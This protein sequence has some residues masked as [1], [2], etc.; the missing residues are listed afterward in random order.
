MAVKLC[1]SS[2]VMRSEAVFVLTSCCCL[3]RQELLCC[4]ISTDGLEAQVGFSSWLVRGN[5]LE[6]ATYKSRSHI[7]SRDD[8]FRAISIPN[9]YS[10]FPVFSLKHSVFRVFDLIIF[11]MR[12]LPQILATLALGSVLGV[13][14]APMGSDAID[15]R[16]ARPPS[17]L[18]YAT[19]ST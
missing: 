13:M 8:S 12:F 6:L 19:Y 9:I 2:P 1:L 10:S 4:N 11:I 3:P 15:V 7:I 5:V 16:D 14:A 17:D 18:Q